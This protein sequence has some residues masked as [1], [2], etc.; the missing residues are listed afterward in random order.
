MR[1][2]SSPTPT[3]NYWRFRTL[4]ILRSSV[5]WT[6]RT[7]RD[8]HRLEGE[9]TRWTIRPWKM[10]LSIKWGRTKRF[11]IESRRQSKNS[12]DQVRSFTN[13][14]LFV[15]ASRKGSRITAVRVFLLPSA[16]SLQETDQ[17]I[18]PIASNKDLTHHRLRLLDQPIDDRLFV[19]VETIAW[20]SVARS[21]VDATAQA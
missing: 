11:D 16:S 20:T 21:I 19:V 13:G 5:R 14:V 10:I 9:A 3:S 15:L 8:D 6:R 2:D 7:C 12:P 17:V 18:T 1:V 4:G